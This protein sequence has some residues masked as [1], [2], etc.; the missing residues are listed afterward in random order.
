MSSSISSR[1]GAVR[2]SPVLVFLG[3]LGAAGAVEGVAGEPPASGLRDFRIPW[4]PCTFVL[5]G[6]DLDGSPQ[7]LLHKKYGPKPAV[8]WDKG[9]GTPRYVA[10]W[11]ELR[12]VSP[13]ATDAELVSAVKGFVAENSEFFGVGVEDLLDGIVTPVAKMR[14]VAFGQGFVGV[15]VRG[16]GLRA[17]ID[18]EGELLSVDAFILRTAALPPISTVVP[19]DAN[20][21]LANVLRI[22]SE[23]PKS[24]TGLT[25]G[26]ID[27]QV[28]FPTDRISDA[29]L[30]WCVQAEGAAGDAWDL[31]LSTEGELLGEDDPAHYA[32]GAGPFE[33]RFKV[34][35]FST[36]PEDIVSAANKASDFF[37]LEGARIFLESGARGLTSPSGDGVLSSE[38]F[39]DVA[40]ADL[41]FAEEDPVAEGCRVTPVDIEE[42][43]DGLKTIFTVHSRPSVGLDTVVTLYDPTKTT[44]LD[45]VKAAS[46]RFE[47]RQDSQVRL[48]AF[49]LLVYHQLR[50]MRE[51]SKATILDSNLTQA[52]TDMFPIRV[53]LT[54]APISADIPRYVMGGVVLCNPTIFLSQKRD[55]QTWIT[56]TIVHHE[57]AHHLIDALVGTGQDDSF[58]EGIAVGLV[59]LANEKP[60]LEL[61]DEHKDPVKQELLKLNLDEESHLTSP[62]LRKWAGAVFWRALQKAKLQGETKARGVKKLFYTWM[63][64]RRVG[65]SN[66][67][68]F[69]PNALLEQLTMTAGAMEPG[70]KRIVRL[71]EVM[72]FVVEFFQGTK[73]HWYVNRF[74][75]GDADHNGVVDL[76]DAIGTLNYLFLGGEEARCLVAHDTDDSTSIDITDPV[77]LLTHLF[78]GG[79]PPPVPYPE[80]GFDGL[81][82]DLWCKE[83]SAACRP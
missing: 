55:R 46:L 47:V 51:R 48:M 17:L 44:R 15:T 58:V 33:G 56:P 26:P 4:T 60:N 11:N 37:P 7:T 2:S 57:Y 69:D 67:I 71:P 59:A 83:T 41:A 29:R 13:E 35:G 27:L 42:P 62:D 1:R 32:G 5:P 64:S 24:G 9:L 34:D 49:D 66:Q 40:W 12:L 30:G 52:A 21:I 36:D 18:Q 75:R 39:D 43:R 68:A 76:T 78:L 28:I 70:G 72:E 82:R 80:C 74:I 45:P 25:P 22:L 79:E 31:F 50:R 77:K 63:A 6:E 38:N 14:L 16:A 20:A 65:Q 54:E 8:Y 3:L 81:P 23:D 53:V 10:F 19:L 73:S 61:I